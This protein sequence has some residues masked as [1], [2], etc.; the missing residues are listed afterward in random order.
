ML[1]LVQL[2]DG[3]YKLIVNIQTD[4]FTIHHEYTFK[5]VESNAEP[6]ENGEVIKI[7]F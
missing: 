3:C 2:T 4:S 5:E 7:D 6:R 1:T